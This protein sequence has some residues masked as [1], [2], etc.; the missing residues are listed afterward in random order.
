MQE[1]SDEWLNVDAETFDENIAELM[2][3]KSSKLQREKQTDNDMQ[4]DKEDEENLIAQVQADKLKG[5][6]KKVERFVEGRG[7]LE[8]A[9]LDE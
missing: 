5:L 1:D 2:K 7:S 6:A 3:S 9:L 8:G 4:V